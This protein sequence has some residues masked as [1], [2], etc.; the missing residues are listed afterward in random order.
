MR[1]PLILLALALL[2]A[3]APLPPVPVYR[4]FGRWLVA[5][6]NTRACVARGFDEGTRAELDLVRAAG[7]VPARLVFSAETALVAADMRMDGKK[8]SFPAPAWSTKD[9]ALST[10]A[11]EAVAAFVAK[12]RD[13]HVVTLDANV[14]AGAEARTVPLDGFSAALLLVDAV[15]GR[16]GTPTAL[17]APKGSAAPPPAPPVPAAPRWVAPPAL[18][19]T[20]VPRLEQQARHLPS[21]A[22]GTCDVKDPPSVYPLD[23]S[24][25]LA[26]RPCYLAAYQGSSVVGVLPRAG[27]PTAPVTLALPGLPKDA[28]DGPDMV[29]PEFDPA[30][31]TLSSVSKGRGLA[32]CGSSETWVW[33]AGAFRMKALEY[34]G[35]C[36]GTDPGDWP[37]LFRTR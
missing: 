3:A 4:E 19:Q 22:F 13:G 32:D 1:T 36:G 10:H 34:Q 14:S 11:P 28:T 17:I 15:Q 29:D 5:C 21:P 16:P 20:E 25:A 23:A 33:N 12:A 24:H 27:G 35:M 7:N 30:S 31:G 18:T 37:P 2:P 6:D 9:E 26:I 8:M